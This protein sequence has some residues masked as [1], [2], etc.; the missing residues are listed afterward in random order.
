MQRWSNK[1]LDAERKKQQ[2]NQNVWTTLNLNQNNWNCETNI[3]KSKYLKLFIYVENEWQIVRS[4]LFL[5]VWKWKHRHY[6]KKKKENDTKSVANLDELTTSVKLNKVSVE[7]LTNE[8]TAYAIQCNSKKIFTVFSILTTYGW[9]F[10][11]YMTV[12]QR[13]CNL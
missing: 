8:N 2:Q 9:K 7:I 5:V 6:I 13:I 1:I 3:C 4:E 12:P 10:K 11:F